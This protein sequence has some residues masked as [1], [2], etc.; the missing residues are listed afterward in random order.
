M[1]VRALIVCDGLIPTNELLKLRISKA[2]LLVACDGAGIHLIGSSFFPD[3]I[4]GDLDSF[5]SDSI[6]TYPKVKTKLIKDENQET[7][8]LEKALNYVLSLGYK[9]VEILGGLGKRIDH[10]LKNLSVLQQFSEQFSLIYFRDEWGISFFSRN[11]TR[12]SAPI[13]SDLSIIPFNGR[14]TGIVTS[15]LEFA[16][17]NEWLENGKRDGTS[18]KMLA[19]H[20]EIKKDSGDLLLVLGLNKTPEIAE[21]SA[22]LNSGDTMH[23]SLISC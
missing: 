21:F 7:N 23:V 11:Q 3:V 1:S 14:V 17:F 2:D 18:N 15:G 10:T 6:I 8:D 12:I 13:H 16:L 9:Q 22:E 5:N 20:C 19:N 4:I